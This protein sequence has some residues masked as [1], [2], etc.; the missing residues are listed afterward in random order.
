M[1]RRP[2]RATRTD[3]LFPYTTLFRSDAGFAGDAEGD[4]DLRA[5]VGLLLQEGRLGD[6]RPQQHAAQVVRG[7]AG[8]RGAQVVLA[9]GEQLEGPR[10]AGLDVEVTGP[11]LG[12]A[13]RSEERR[14]GTECVR[15]CKS[16]W[17]THTK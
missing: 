17:Y 12:E 9:G 13:K 4:A 7:R 10:A 16:R 3:T 8:V 6:V 15:T 14:V 2:P 11:R 1:I 5:L